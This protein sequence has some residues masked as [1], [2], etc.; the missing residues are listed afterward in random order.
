MFSEAKVFFRV[1]VFASY[2]TATLRLN[3]R[4][5]LERCT[6]QILRDFMT[7]NAHSARSL[8]L[9]LVALVGAA[10]VWLY[11]QR[12]LIP[13]QVADAA[14]HGRPRGN[15]SDLYP[16]WLGARELLLHG[17][18]PYSAAVTREIQA[19]YYGR[20]L[21]PSRPGDPPTGDPKDQQAFAYPVYVVFWLAPIL[22]L[23]FPA[24]QRAFLYL[25][26][27]LTAASALLWLP[28]L[29]IRLSLIQKTIVA[30]LTLGSLP[31]LQ[32]LKLQQ[33]SLLVAGLITIA[34]FLLIHD[35]QM[36]AGVLLAWA[37][38]KPQLLALTL[39]WLGIWTLADLR[40]RYRW[41]LSFVIAM[42]IQ[43]A[44]AEWYLPHW[45]PQFL[46]AVREYRQY[47]EA[48]SVAEV[49]TGRAFG[50][51]VEIVAFALLMRLC[52]RERGA[53]RDSE[54]F[55]AITAV[56][57]AFTVLLIPTDSIYNQVLLIPAVLLLVRDRLAIWKQDS[58]ARVLLG[59]TAVLVAW[60]WVSS[61]ALV[62][63]SFVLP[64]TMVERGWAV[65]FW[66]SLAAPVG[67]AGA[68]LLYAWR[69]TFAATCQPRTS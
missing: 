29:R 34:I 1:A 4:Y 16:R 5:S 20:A 30:A 32:G 44:A 69:Q 37:S 51:L 49:L 53:P 62:G 58:L 11:A 54:S 46:S 14:V 21:V 41:A 31:A 17:R 13:F 3:D 63:L 12:V 27:A 23:P 38:M 6:I 47:T 50:M 43:I 45:I 65:P 39:V 22:K 57:S 24:V 35:Y 64:Q 33:L 48:I 26:A 9:V 7:A 66:M 19:G 10:C 52:W 18:N 36:A 42:A 40:R 8:L 59:V 2:A 68:I 61:A 60:P 67:V 25:L 56:V 55:A 15:L 28:M